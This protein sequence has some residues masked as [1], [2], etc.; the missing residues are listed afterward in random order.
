[1]TLEGKAILSLAEVEVYPPT[2]TDD[3]VYNC[4]QSDAENVEI[5]AGGGAVLPKNDETEEEKRDSDYNINKTT[6]TEALN[7]IKAKEMSHFEALKPSSSETT[8]S[9]FSTEHRRQTSKV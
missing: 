8:T 1:M 9:S 7:E 3:A 6:V 5:I 4:L 2:S